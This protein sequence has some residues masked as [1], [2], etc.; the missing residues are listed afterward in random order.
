M[1]FGGKGGWEFAWRPRGYCSDMVR[2]RREA[3]GH[4]LSG[5]AKIACKFEYWTDGDAVERA[6]AMQWSALYRT[7]FPAHLCL[8]SLKQNP[9][10]TELRS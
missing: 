7:L 2:P 9:K 4:R 10:G 3:G 1:T 8:R 6:W 5:S